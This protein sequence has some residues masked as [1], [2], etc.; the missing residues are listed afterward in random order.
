MLGQNTLSSSGTTLQL[1]GQRHLTYYTFHWR[2]N[3]RYRFNLDTVLSYRSLCNSCRIAYTSRIRDLLLLFLLVLTCQISILTFTTRCYAIYNCGCWCRGSLHLQMWWQ[4]LTAYNTLW[5]SRPAYRAYT[6]R[7]RELMYAAD[8]V[9]SSSC[10]RIIGK[11]FQNPGNTDMY[12]I[13]AVR[14]RIT[15]HAVPNRLIDKH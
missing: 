13:S 7:D 1:H 5:E 10:T 3:R 9:I 15:P 11:Y 12:I 4:G 6:Y 2:V 8:A 14:C